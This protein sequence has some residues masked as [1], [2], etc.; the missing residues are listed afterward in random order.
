MAYYKVVTYDEFAQMF[1]DR[2]LLTGSTLATPALSTIKTAIKNNIGLTGASNQ[3]VC[4]DKSLTTDSI[5]YL[6][7]WNQI[8]QGKINIPSPPNEIAS[9][10]FPI[11]MSSVDDKQLLSTDNI[12]LNGTVFDIKDT[13]TGMTYAY[14]GNTV[15]GNITVNIQIKPYADT[16]YR[17]IGYISSGS[18]GLTKASAGGVFAS[19]ESEESSDNIEWQLNVSL[20]YKNQQI[21]NSSNKIYLDSTPYNLTLSSQNASAANLSAIIIGKS[22]KDMLAVKKI[23]LSLNVSNVDS[24]T[25]DLTLLDV[26]GVKIPTWHSGS[27]IT[28]NIPLTGNTTFGSGGWATKNGTSFILEFYPKDV[29]TTSSM[30]QITCT[31][32]TYALTYNIEIAQIKTILSVSTSYWVRVPI[33]YNSSTYYV[34]CLVYVNG[35]G[36]LSLED[37]EGYIEIIPRNQTNKGYVDN[38][39]SVSNVNFYNATEQDEQYYINYGNFYLSDIDRSVLSSIKVK[40]GVGGYFNFYYNYQ[41]TKLHS[42]KIST[43]SYTMI[44]LI[45]TYKITSWDTLRNLIDDTLGSLQYRITIS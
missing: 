13:M 36:S 16:V 14:T 25:L 11:K 29:P 37:S 5:N 40:F 24:P 45:D 32:S 15:N 12:S 35:E 30:K 1:I 21:N 4:V 42:T 23:G 27:G 10:H 39:S 28:N 43:N 22:I 20:S 44:S 9:H 26:R 34:W 41:A 7:F 33:M 2:M 17:T 18:T 3:C 19:I 6:V 8:L 38:V 31:G